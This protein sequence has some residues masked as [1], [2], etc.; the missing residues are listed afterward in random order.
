MKKIILIFD[1]CTT[2]FRETFGGLHLKYG[3]NPDVAI[4][5]KALG[6][7]YAINDL[8][9]K[10]IMENAQNTFI[11]SIWTERSGPSAAIKTLEIMK[12]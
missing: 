7:G 6:N 12:N 1:E 11:S 9:K 5:G 3:I 10:E 4:F 8:G 2:G